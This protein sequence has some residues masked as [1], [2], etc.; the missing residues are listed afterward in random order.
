MGPVKKV[1]DS[2]LSDGNKS[3]AKPVAPASTESDSLKTNALEV[4]S[5]AQPSKKLTV[6]AKPA[7]SEVKSDPEPKKVAPMLKPSGDVPASA[8]GS[9][10]ATS[11]S[12]KTR[13]TSDKKT[14]PAREQTST[15]SVSK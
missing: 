9:Q 3:A 8:S 1:K 11:E 2:E 12:L 7:V 15:S 10:K 4:S 13:P 14:E 6:M 5:K